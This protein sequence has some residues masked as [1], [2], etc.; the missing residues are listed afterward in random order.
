MF[1]LKR[2]S[3][4]RDRGF[5]FGRQK[6]EMHGMRNMGFFNLIITLK[7]L[8]FSKKMQRK[9]HIIILKYHINSKIIQL[10]KL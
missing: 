5:C 3:G 8:S 10:I 2:V 9:Y 1:Y 6:R 7:C 4:E